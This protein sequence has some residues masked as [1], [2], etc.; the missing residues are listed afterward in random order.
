MMEDAHNVFVAYLL[1][2]IIII[3]VPTS[4]CPCRYVLAFSEEVQSE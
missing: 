2:T 4:C 3:T 1:G